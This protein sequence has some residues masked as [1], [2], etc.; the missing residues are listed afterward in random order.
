V[1]LLERAQFDTIADL[2]T[3]HK[4]ILSAGGPAS[5][6]LRSL[7]ESVVRLSRRCPQPSGSAQCLLQNSF[8][9]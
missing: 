3:K 2:D 6:H 7:A 4:F 9:V 5:P 1:I 8:Y